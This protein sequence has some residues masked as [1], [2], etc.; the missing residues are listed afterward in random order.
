VGV[1]YVSVAQGLQAESA[2]LTLMMIVPTLRVGMHPTTLRVTLR[3]QDAERPGRRYHAERGS[4]QKA[5][6]EPLVDTVNSDSIAQ[7][8]IVLTLP[9]ALQCSAKYG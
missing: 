6:G 5:P 1:E 7:F 9:R 3:Y 4:D 2:C 8:Q